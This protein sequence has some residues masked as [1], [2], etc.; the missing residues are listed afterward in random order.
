LAKVRSHRKGLPQIS[1]RLREVLAWAA[2][3]QELVPAQEQ[4]VFVALLTSPEGHRM[5]LR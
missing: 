5:A 4:Q 3:E 2:R 1:S